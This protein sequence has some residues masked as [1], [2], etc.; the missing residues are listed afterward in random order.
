[1]TRADRVLA[2]GAWIAAADSIT[3]DYD[4]RRQRRRL[5]TA[6]GGLSFL[7][8]LPRPTLLRD[9]D[10]LALDDGRI[11]VVRAA[12]EKLTEVRADLPLALTRAAW[13]LGNR[14]LPVQVLPDAL[15][16]RPDAVIH[17]MLERLG[18]SLRAIE[19]PFEPEG[20]A[21]ASGHAHDS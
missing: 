12:A 17:E 3:L 18:L 8:D 14:H 4:G 5:L 20:G 16:L 9:G 11:V 19:A 2:P 21:Y 7:L 1:M 15:R 6:R 10:G 13:H